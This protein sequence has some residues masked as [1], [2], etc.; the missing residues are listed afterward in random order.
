MGSLTREQR[1]KRNN[2][3]KEIIKPDKRLLEACEALRY[4]VEHPNADSEIM[5]AQ[6]V[7][8]KKDPGALMT[9]YVDGVV[10]GYKV[11]PC[12]PLAINPYFDRYAYVRVPEHRL[13]DLT[14]REMAAIKMAML[15]AFFDTQQGEIKVEVIGD[16]ALL[17]WQ[18][19]MVT[20]PVKFQQATIQVPQGFNG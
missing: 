17:M 7:Y 20:F 13:T 9:A 8:R 3:L 1:L 18:R 16:G 12:S 6:G 11:K 15:E 5:M 4:T 19:F 10:I 2:R 14:D